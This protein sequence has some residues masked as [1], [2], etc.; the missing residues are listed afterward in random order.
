MDGITQALLG[1]VVGQAS[2]GQRLG[3]RAAW[4][5]AL[6]GMLPDAD[7]FVSMPFDEFTSMW[8]HRGESHS[9]WFGPVVGP[10]LGWGV[11]RVHRARARRRDPTV[12]LEANS[13]TARASLRAWV[14]LF[15]LA[16]LTHPLLDVFTT[17]GTQLL[18]P[19]SR[20][21]FALDGVGIIDPVYS[22]ILIVAL[23]WGSAWRQ[24]PRRAARVAQ[25]ALALSTSYLLVG[26][27]MTHRV[28]Q[29]AARE[30]TA[31]G[32]PV[33][34][35][36]AYT[37]VFQFGLKRVVAHSGNEVL[38]GYVSGLRPSP[39]EWLSFPLEP[40]PDVDRVLATPRGEL[41][42]WFAN[43][44][45]TWRVIP[46]PP[47]DEPAQPPSDSVSLR[48]EIDD[49]RYGMPGRP[50]RGFWGIV[51]HVSPSGEV[52]EVKRLT[53]PRDIR[54]GQIADIFRAAWGHDPRTFR[55]GVGASVKPYELSRDRE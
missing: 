51:A 31:H 16:L 45:L 39:I 38:V 43:G 37:S 48:V 41:F 34:S 20:A 50:D 24:Q 5:G 27:W 2:V 47:A 18:A 32:Y 44:Q 21:R 52:S 36:H 15:I 1:A 17:Y 13:V 9:L 46:E 11:W 22:V 35:I 26:L 49:L 4:W 29:R 7:I 6:G 55:V 33:S 30:L 25:G 3:R 54:D 14:L 19:F 28:E 40:H 23:A 10:L 42:Q 53:R 8:V 12:D